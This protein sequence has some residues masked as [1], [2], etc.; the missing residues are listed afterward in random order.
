MKEAHA[1]GAKMKYL[2]FFGGNYSKKAFA[3]ESA[4]ITG[5]NKSIALNQ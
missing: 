1:T 2:H 5:V 4:I 3:V